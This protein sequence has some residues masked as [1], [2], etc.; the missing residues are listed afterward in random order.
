[1]L[2]GVTFTYCAKGSTDIQN[3]DNNTISIN[4]FSTDTE[5]GVATDTDYIVTAY[6]NGVSVATALFRVYHRVSDVDY[7]LYG[8]P[9]EVKYNA[10]LGGYNIQSLLITVRKTDYNGTV[11]YNTLAELRNNNASFIVECYRDDS[12]DAI[13]PTEVNGKEYIYLPPNQDAQ[14][15]T[16]KL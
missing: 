12:S 4:G 9:T 11:T 3:V 2:E 5:N 7:D 10:D 6:V 13:E 15:F 14:L 1:M 8:L 16:I